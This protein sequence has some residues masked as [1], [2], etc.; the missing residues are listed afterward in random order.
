MLFVWLF[1]VA[2]VVVYS[3]GM[4][5]QT[6]ACNK[7]LSLLV[8]LACTLNFN[9]QALVLF[10]VSDFV[11]CESFLGCFLDVIF[12]TMVGPV[13]RGGGDTGLHLPRNTTSYGGWER[14]VRTWVWLVV[15][16]RLHVRNAV[17]RDSLLCRVPGGNLWEDHEPQ[18]EL[19]EIAVD[20]VLCVYITTT[21]Y[22]LL[23]GAYNTQHTVKEVRSIITVD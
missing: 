20:F 6:S 7:S 14:K 13:L 21:H 9:T 10:F 23:M 2:E 5:S 19:I 12:P 18:G 15:S 4:L 11:S 1:A 16:G 8:P 3:S 17:R 22:H